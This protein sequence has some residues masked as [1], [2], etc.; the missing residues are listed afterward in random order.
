MG[1]N[2]ITGHRL[3][4]R[5]AIDDSYQSNYENIFKKKEVPVGEDTRPKDRVKQGLSSSTEVEEWD[6][7]KDPVVITKASGIALH[8]QKNNHN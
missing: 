7:T 4:S 5:V 6:C 8:L 1:T 3:V 2:D